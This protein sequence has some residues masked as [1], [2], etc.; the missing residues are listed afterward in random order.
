MIHVAFDI[1]N[2]LC[3]FDLSIF[4]RRLSEII[5]INDHDAFFF[6]EHI[7]KLQDIGATSVADSLKY[8]FVLSQSDI[9]TLL[10]AWNATLTPSE[11]MLS[12]MDK[13][14]F[15]GIKIALLSNMGPEH[16]QY[17]RKEC[18]RM[19]DNTHQHI[20]SEVG[21]RKPNKL[22]FQSFFLDHDEFKGCVYVD[23]IE[24]NLKI[25]KKYSFKVY[26]FNL[27]S[28][29]KLPLGQQKQELDRLQQMITNKN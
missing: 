24:E 20:S 11:M 23:D 16:I 28:I 10:E 27:D 9:D 19:F 3:Q 22:F 13:L 1:G 25:G 2:V 26:Q 7:Q 17:L 18:P 4:T 5:G 6:L 12:F 8:K 15:D 29:L 21:A 14:R